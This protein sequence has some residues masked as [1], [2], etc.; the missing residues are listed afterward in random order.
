MEFIDVS[1][2]VPTGVIRNDDCN[3][4][5]S[6]LSCK[7]TVPMIHRLKSDE[8]N[9]WTLRSGI[10][11]MY[12]YNLE[13]IIF[14]SYN[15]V[16]ESLLFLMSYHYCSSDPMLTCIMNCVCVTV[17]SNQKH[18]YNPFSDTAVHVHVC[19]SYQWSHQEKKL[20]RNFQ[21]LFI[22]QIT[23]SKITNNNE[24]KE[25]R[26]R[27]SRIVLGILKWISLKI[28]WNTLTTSEDVIID[29]LVLIPTGIYCCSN[30]SLCWHNI[31]ILLVLQS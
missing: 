10:D 25:S 13:R 11:W 19:A 18:P 12:C 4:K 16:F 17:Q 21:R 22:E 29:F 23:G 14:L 3:Q 20:F 31:Y 8:N 26:I 1:N 15:R 5:I 27:I 7:K 30:Q 9:D 28:T 24:R 6:P 2:G